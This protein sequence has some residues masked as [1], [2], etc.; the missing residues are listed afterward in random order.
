M[1]TQTAQEM[2]KL[3]E[4]TTKAA[5]KDQGAEA[6]ETKSR[7]WLWLIIIIVVGLWP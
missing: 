2:K 4:Q 1:Q 3:E 7:W 5:Q 6:S